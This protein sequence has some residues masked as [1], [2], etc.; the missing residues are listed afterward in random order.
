MKTKIKKIKWIHQWVEKR[1][2]QQKVK[3]HESQESHE[4][5][6]LVNRKKKTY[7]ENIKAQCQQNSKYL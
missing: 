5:R 3:K 2:A 6:E 1:N 7:L 4:N